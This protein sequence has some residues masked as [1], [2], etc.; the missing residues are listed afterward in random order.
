MA[1]SDEKEQH[2]NDVSMNGLDLNQSS[3]V[4]ITDESIIAL[5]ASTLLENEPEDISDIDELAGEYTALNNAIDEINNYLDRWETRHDHLRAEILKVLKENQ[6]EENQRKES[7][8]N[9]VESDSASNKQDTH[10]HID[11]ESS[12]CEKQNKNTQN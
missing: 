8:L 10:T 1:N 9:N 2:V 3:D 5:L 6:E 4:A 7:L 12:T 11:L